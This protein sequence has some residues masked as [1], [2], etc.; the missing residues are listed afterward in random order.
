V[1]GK[2]ATS[3][4]LTFFNIEDVET[5]WLIKDK[6]PMAKFVFVALGARSFKK[7]YIF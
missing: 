3:K 5:H 4:V 2:N 7:L 1:T 6:R